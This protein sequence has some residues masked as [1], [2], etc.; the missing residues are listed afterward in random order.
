MAFIDVVPEEEAD[1]PVADMYGRLRDALGYVPNY[2]KV[3][4]HRPELFA[5][6]SRLNTTIKDAMD[7]RVY[8]LATLAAAAHRRSSYCVLAHGEKL[9]GLGSS[10]EEVRDLVER[11]DT[12]ALSDKERAVVEFAR[13]VASDPV[14]I[15]AADVDDLRAVGLDEAE[16]FDV[17][18]AAAARLFFTAL[19]DAMGSHPDAAYRQTFT[20]L[21]DSLAVGRSLEDQAP[22]AV[23]TA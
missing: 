18:A 5:A 8:E 1:G 15:D 11:G 16:I 2:G 23:P 3:F 14:A 12:A 19:Q 21:A 9:L 13:K 22:P 6:W 7:P 17:A 20:D 10:P 4:S